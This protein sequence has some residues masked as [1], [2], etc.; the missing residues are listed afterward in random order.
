[1]LRASKADRPKAFSA[2][3]GKA[4][5][6]TCC[7]DLSASNPAPDVAFVETNIVEQQIA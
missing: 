6:A 5:A 2:T 7:A 4:N 3:E 1:M